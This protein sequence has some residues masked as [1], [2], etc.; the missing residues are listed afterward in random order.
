MTTLIFM[1]T[2]LGMAV[3]LSIIIIKAISD[4]PVKPSLKAMGWIV[5]TYIV[6]WVVFDLT[7]KQVNIPPGTDVCFDDWCAT[8]LKAERQPDTDSIRIAL[9]VRV[10]NHARGIA[11]TPSE[12]RVHILDQTGRSWAYSTAAQKD[13]ERLNGTQPGIAHRLALGRSLETVM[14]FA[15]PKNSVRLT[16]KIEEGPWI[17]N[18]LFPENEQVFAL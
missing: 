16:A 12:P 14:V 15:L 4:Q 17:T 9:R 10:S 11:Q 6:L 2:V 7:R 13:F 18:L 8:V 1:L 5:L 3:Q